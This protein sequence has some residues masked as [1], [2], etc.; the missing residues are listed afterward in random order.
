MVLRSFVGGLFGL[1]ISPV[2]LIPGPFVLLSTTSWISFAVRSERP[3][4]SFF[5]ASMNALMFLCTSS[6]VKP[7][8]PTDI[9]ITPILSLYSH[10]RRKHNVKATAYLET[11]LHKHDQ[12]DQKYPHVEE[13]LASHS[14]LVTREYVGSA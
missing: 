6:G 14:S 8:C 3:A 5:S 1:L 7:S 9:L 10:L 13:F 12:L 2:K 11:R 4:M